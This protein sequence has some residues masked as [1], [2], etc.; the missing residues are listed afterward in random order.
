MLFG[1]I[2]GSGR[3]QGAGSHLHPRSKPL[4]AWG[5][6]QQVAR[7][8]ILYTEARERKVDEGPYGNGLA[9]PKG[10]QS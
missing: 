2:W 3:R 4:L 9:G 10:G 5:G 7:I 6:G 1:V 8:W